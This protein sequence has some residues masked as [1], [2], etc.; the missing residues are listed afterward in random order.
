MIMDMKTEKKVE[1]S[2]QASEQSWWKWVFISIAAVIFVVMPLMSLD[3]GISTDEDMYQYPQALLVYEYYASMG[4]N[5]SYISNSI[6]DMKYWPLAFDTFTVFIVKALNIDDYMTAR[7]VCNALVG[8]FLMLF[9]GLL[10]RLIGGWRAGCMA[11]LLIFLSPH[12]VG[13]SFN[14]P[15][16]IPF[17]ACAIGAIY[18]IA[19]FIKEYPHPTLKTSLKLGLMMGASLGVRP[20]GFLFFAYFGL[21][22][23]VYYLM[24]N[25]PKQY[26]SKGNRA[27]LK[28]IFAQAAVVLGAML[29]VMFILWPYALRDPRHHIVFFFKLLSHIPVELYQIFEGKSIWSKDYPWYYTLKY[30]GITSPIAVLIGGGGT[31]ICG[32]AAAT[33][34]LLLDIRAAVL[35]C[36]SPFLDCLH[37]S[38]RLLRLAALNICL[39]HAG[40]R[41]GVGL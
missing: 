19:W 26:F 4:Q 35:F 40:G 39:P 18:Y 41:R 38:H 3:A 5:T 21:F 34:R 11:L 37:Q 31:V 12:I 9:V 10:A 13:Q 22:V 25:K 29:G 6:G 20:G 33:E 24:V 1:V 17:A 7:H 2:S 32:G 8:A 28:K 27:I 14:N 16:D 23:L 15:K 30:I 36:L